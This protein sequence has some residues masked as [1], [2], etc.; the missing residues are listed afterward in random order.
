[1]PPDENN[2]APLGL[3]SA[4]DALLAP[5]P[6]TTADPKKKRAPKVEEVTASEGSVKAEEAAV[7]SSQQ[8]TVDPD[9][10]QLQVEDDAEDDAEGPDGEPEDEAE[11]ESGDDADSGDAEDDEDADDSEPET[12]FELDDGT[13]VD[14]DELKRG[15]LRQ[16]DYTKKTQEVAE[17]RK[18]LQQAYQARQQERQTLAE[19]LN[20]ALGVVEPQ[21]AELARTDW[22]RLATED[23]YS[24]AEKRALF[25]QASV[26]YNKLVQQAQTVVQKQQQETQQQLQQ[27]LQQEGQRLRMAI[28][29]FADPKRSRALKGAITE[30][31]ISAMGLS[32]QEAKGITDH[33]MIVLLN[34]ARQ[35]DA[36]QRGDLSAARKKVSKTP[37]KALQA[38]SPKTKSERQQRA[39]ADQMSKLRQTGKLDDAVELLMGH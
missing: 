9:K 5:E 8:P 29:D 34:K 16:S 17:A 26:R 36:L 3:S 31:A 11:D 24:Y 13:K 19:N 33:R 7:R 30:Y 2:S 27:R 18:H 20:L 21:L 38:G 14:L 32:E 22:D 37:K 39:R 6:S 28:P 12:V 35:F 1:M 23:P 15:Y 10:E 25:D 4:V